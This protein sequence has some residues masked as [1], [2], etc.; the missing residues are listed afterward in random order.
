MHDLKKMLATK[1]PKKQRGIVEIQSQDIGLHYS[2]VTDFLDYVVGYDKDMICAID[3]LIERF[4]LGAVY[5]EAGGHYGSI[6]PRIGRDGKI[7]GGNVIHFDV[8]NGNVLKTAN[9]A[10]HLCQRYGYDYYEDQ[11]VFFGEHTISFKPVAVVQDEKTA[12]LGSLAGYPFDWLAV[13]HG[14][15]LTKKMIDKLH[16]RSVIL[17][18]H[19]SVVQEWEIL[20]GSYVKVDKTFANT[21]IDEY[22]VGRIKEKIRIN[23]QGTNI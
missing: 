3:R 23:K 20:F 2:S 6:L 5:E 4:R 14:R 8:N 18:P 7:A 9:L 21:D 15:K 10:G 12:L 22:L 16:G 17:F 1:A 11:D 19:G 13:G